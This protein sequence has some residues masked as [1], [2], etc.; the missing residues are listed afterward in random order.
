MLCPIT[1]WSQTASPN[2]A[3]FSKMF[4]VLPPSPNASS[5]GKYG[6]ID[7]GLASGMANIEI[8]VY[9]LVSNNLKVP[10]S[11]AYSSNGFRVDELPGRIGTGWSL[12]AGGVITRSVFGS[13][14][15][16]YQRLSPPADFPA[17]S[18]ALVNFME[19]LA[20]SAADNFG[21]D[22]QPDL[23]SFNFNGYSGRF[24]LDAN[25][26]PILLSHSNLK[27]ER[28]FQST[29]WNFK[30][31]TPD[32]VQYLFGGTTAIEKTKRIQTGS[33]CGR[34]YSTFIPTAWY[35]KQIIH[36]NNDV[37]TFTYVPLG[38]QYST[39]INQAI[40]ARNTLQGYTCAGDNSN[41]PTQTNTICESIMQTSGV[42][43]QEITSTG[44]AKLK[45][46]YID[47][48]DGNEKLLS[49]VEVYPP[50][51]LTT[52]R[53]FNLIYQYSV[54][55]NFKNSFS[56]GD[57]KLNSRPFLM[58]VTE[59]SSDALL[60]KNHSF[61][62]NDISSLPPRLSFAQDHYGFFNG[63][64]NTT[65][66]PLPSSLTWQKALPLASANRDVDPLFCQKG[67]LTSITYPTGGKDNITYEAN[68]VYQDVSIYPS[69]TMISAGAYNP[70]YT[71]GPGVTNYSATA[72]VAFQQ[73]IFFTGQCS[74]TG[75]GDPLH[76]QSVI[77]LL[78]ENNNVIYSNT[79]Q[80]G[81]YFNK[82]LYLSAGHSYRIK[83]TSN[84]NQVSGGASF[85]VM[86]GNIVHQNM[87]VNVGGVRV[88][89]IISTD[90]VTT[91]SA[92]KKFLY[93]KLAT[94]AISSGGKVYAPQY[95]KYLTLKVPCNN[96][97]P[98]TGA[99]ELNKYD[100][101]SMYSNSINNM[102]IYPAS[103][104]SY[105]NVI[106]S[107]GENF[108]NGGIEHEFTVYED[109][110]AY[111]V[112]GIS[113]SLGAPMT[114]YSWKNAREIYQH[115]FKKQGASYL[116]VKKI[117][118]TYKEDTRIDQDLKAYVVSKNY[119]VPCTTTIP[120]TLEIESYDLLSFSHF[121]KWVYIDNIKSWNYDISGQTYLEEI[122]TSEYAN[123]IHALPTKQTTL[124]S[125]GIGSNITNSYAQ[126]ITLSGTEETARQTLISKYMIG[127]LLQQQIN[128]GAGQLFTLKTGYN[129]FPNGLVLPQTRYTQKVGN[130]IEERVQY[131]SYNSYGKIL[132]QSKKSDTRQSYI[133][134][135]LSSYPLA[136]V[137][138]AS[139]V[140]IAFTSFEFEGKGGW[141]FTGTPVAEALT[142]TG[143]NA[144]Q[145]GSSVTKTGLPL[146]TYIVS[147]WVKNGSGTPL[148]N[149]AT[150]IA[151]TNI[152]G[153]TYY[154]HKIL[155]PTAGTI[156]VSGTGKIDELRLYPEKAQ[157]IS[158][159]Y[160]PLIGITSQ[161]DINNRVTYYEYDGLGRVI[162]IR[163]QDRNILKK[164]C[165]NYAGQPEN[166]V[167]NVPLWQNTATPIRCKKNT[168]NQNTGEQEQEQKDQ[169]PY[170]PT[171]N[172]L[173]WNVTGTN[174][175]AC[176]VTLIIYAKVNY[177][178]WYYDVEATYATVLI[179]FY[180]DAACTIPV[181][182][183]N[184]SVNYKKAQTFCTGGVTTYNYSVTCTGTQ[185]SLGS[186]LIARDDGLHCY[187]YSFQVL[188]GTGYTEK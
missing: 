48:N 45:F 185:A 97:I 131:A 117:F 182:V 13:A 175:T 76:D 40:Y 177:T 126:D 69:Q 154:E 98:C 161:C 60:V 116:P 104:T 113:V 179:N 138:N 25:N 172:Q 19:A 79:L 2:M 176:P 3:D 96:G 51:Q 28:D 100:F 122:T 26:N 132:E 102:Y 125:D 27:I 169:N 106:E 42:L 156:T 16:S 41:P 22:A 135:D 5:L 4:D 160:E 67:L 18:R 167:T 33:G 184:L 1:I 140:S 77:S 163:D 56:W 85:S 7:L 134:S 62:Y 111:Q 112:V 82:V 58:Q 49:T 183:S 90:A 68:Q 66:I 152:N 142:P 110:P 170:S 38:L 12:N 173:R 187:D 47:R 103:P 24:I 118:T 11:L 137:I 89:K 149:A 14:D 57:I 129:V 114:S 30:I 123:V 80:P 93:S 147:Y 6:G 84:G 144:C 143:K 130:A 86:L 64:P 20:V 121:R 23:F 127:T 124:T 29:T 53:I 52:S 71:G 159:T 43:L 75:P 78:D 174:L 164:I 8:P 139:S 101:Y 95:E 91:V 178:N 94:P 171:Y 151:G 109:I 158:Y 148:V 72:A 61:L 165:Y 105:R 155:N 50:G 73:E 136:Q 115:V 36:P 188:P 35:L 81:G 87:N 145:L 39:G 157:M 17:R 162:L 153:W 21:P 65:L 133:W 32:G 46:V 83:C 168:S 107:F 141:T 92:T 10:V 37:V 31:T 119:T 146:D 128:K 120:S 88:A 59:K 186:L 54:A 63:K 150:G 180:S 74:T 55:T 99:F 34:S 181:S 9:E 108:E 15:E 166:C 70:V 44:G